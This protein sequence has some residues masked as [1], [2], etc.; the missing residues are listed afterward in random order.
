M[1]RQPRVFIGSSSEGKAI[2]DAIQVGMDRDAEVTVWDQG[3]FGLSKGTLENLVEL[4]E[5][6]DFAVLVLTPDDL[7][8]KR[9]SARNSPRDN[10]LFELGFFMGALGRERTFMVYSRDDPPELPSDL[11]G[12]TAATFGQRSDGNLQAAVGAVCTQLLDAIRKE[13]ER[14]SP[15]TPWVDMSIEPGGENHV[16][17]NVRYLEPIPHECQ[18]I[19]MDGNRR[20]LTGLPLGWNRIHPEPNKPVH[21]ETIKI[22]PLKGNDVLVAELRVRGLVGKGFSRPLEFTVRKAYRRPQPTILEEIPV[23]F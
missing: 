11:A 20:Y 23:P 15:E 10:V 6:F 12:I 8:Q 14:S 18:F 3:A 17:L 13:L 1:N 9:G 19:I 5:D 2:A 7:V 21:T 4:P 16:K 22:G